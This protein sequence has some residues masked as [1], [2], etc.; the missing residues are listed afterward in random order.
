MDRIVVAHQA[1]GVSRM[2]DPC[3]GFSEHIGG[4]DGAGDVCHFD[5]TIASPVLDGEEW[6][7]DV[8]AALSRNV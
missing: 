5:E 7:F 1:T 6:D 2:E 3:K 4:V 8:T